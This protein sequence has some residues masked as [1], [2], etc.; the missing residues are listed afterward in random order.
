[1][2]P[3]NGSLGVPPTQ[4][5]PRYTLVGVDSAPRIIVCVEGGGELE[6]GGSEYR[7]P[8]RMGDVFM[9]PPAIQGAEF[10]PRGTTT[11]LEIGLPGDAPTSLQE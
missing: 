9:L 7:Y 10:H 2:S 3:V 11:V 4:S 5:L 6:A 1:M 8:V